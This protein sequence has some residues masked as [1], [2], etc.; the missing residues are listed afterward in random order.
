MH[1]RRTIDEPPKVGITPLIDVVFLL[2]IFF[3]VSTTFDRQGDI[4][5]LLPEAQADARI[6]TAILEV[7]VDVNGRYFIG[8]QAVVDPQ[9]QNLKRALANHHALRSEPVRIRADAETSHQ[10]VVT[11]MDLLAEAG[12]TKVGLATVQTSGPVNE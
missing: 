4:R 9:T 11:V 1:F 7:V 10:S 3:M 12:F 5:V 2:L 6:E 8:G